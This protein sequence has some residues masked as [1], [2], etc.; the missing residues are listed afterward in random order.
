MKLDVPA[1]WNILV[2]VCGAPE[3]LR[4]DFLY[5]LKEHAERGTVGSA[6][7]G[8]LEFRFCGR[9]GFGGKVYISGESVY[10]GTYPEELND[11]RRDVIVKANQELSKL[12]RR[13]VGV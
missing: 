1:L 2:N 13:K 11:E 12:V 4:G 3:H 7:N 9:L 8:P 10:V 5:R 6:A